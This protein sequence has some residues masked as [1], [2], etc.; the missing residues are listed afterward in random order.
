MSSIALC[1]YCTQLLVL[2]NHIANLFPV[3]EKVISL[4][5]NLK[6]CKYI[7]P[8]SVVSCCSP[9]WIQ[10]IHFYCIKS[11]FSSRGNTVGETYAVE[12]L[13]R[14]WA[15]L[16]AFWREMNRLSYVHPNKIVLLFLLLFRAVRT[17]PTWAWASNRKFGTKIM[18]T[19][20]RSRKVSFLLFNDGEIYVNKNSRSFDEALISYKRWESL[21][22]YDKV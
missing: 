19:K 9:I 5:S 1:N 17:I 11:S 6:Y 21:I 20:T 4:S 18:E 12:S 10:K 8:V 22:S 16:F 3:L 13:E 7:K 14:E 2:R 15:R